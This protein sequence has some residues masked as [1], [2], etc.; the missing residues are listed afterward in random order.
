MA[1]DE[2]LA[3]R[4][5]EVLAGEAELTER[6]TF[7]VLVATLPPKQPRRGRGAGAEPRRGGR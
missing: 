5:R 4:L 7:G 3:G 2:R 1:Y 6:R